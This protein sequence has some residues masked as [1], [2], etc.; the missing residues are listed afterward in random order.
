[1]ALAKGSRLG[2]ARFFE[3]TKVTGIKQDNGRVTGV[4]TGK[5]EIRPER[6][7]TR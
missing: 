1:M 2:G 3:E 5:G 4:I 7:G 6:M